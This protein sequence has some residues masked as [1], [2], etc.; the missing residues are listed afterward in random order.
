MIRKILDNLLVGIIP[1]K[2]Q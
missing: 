1:N 2:P